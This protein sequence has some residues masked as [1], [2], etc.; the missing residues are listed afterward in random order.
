MKFFVTGRVHP[1]RADVFFPVTWTASDGATVSVSCT[2][3][4]L[5]VW[6][7]PPLLKR[8]EGRNYAAKANF[9]FGVM[10]P[11]AMLGRS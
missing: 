4:Q 2:S 1:E 8:P 7:I 6:V 10:P 9:C 3:S 11:M 5:G